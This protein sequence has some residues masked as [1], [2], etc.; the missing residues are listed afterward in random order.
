MNNMAIL[1]QPSDSTQTRMAIAA[2][3]AALA[4]AIGD[5][6]PTFAKGFRDHLERIQMMEASAGH[7]HTHLY[8]MET[9]SWTIALMDQ[10]E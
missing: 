9:L 10:L 3:F 6:S 7:D 1:Q 2:H 4:R 5:Q 8:L